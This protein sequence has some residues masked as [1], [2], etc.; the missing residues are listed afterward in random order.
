VD[1]VPTI[2][3]DGAK[4]TWALSLRRPDA[5][6]TVIAVTVAAVLSPRV[7]EVG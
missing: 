5:P 1:A 4:V 6:V 2:D 3:V 7:Y